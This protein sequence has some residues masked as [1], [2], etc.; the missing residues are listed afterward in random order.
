MTC[1]ELLIRSTVVLSTHREIWF[2]DIQLHLR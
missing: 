1:I 2:A